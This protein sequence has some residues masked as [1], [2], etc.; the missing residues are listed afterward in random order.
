RLGVNV[1]WDRGYARALAVDP[2][3]PQTIYLGIDG[4]PEPARNH[5][6]G[7]VFKSTDGGKTWQ[8]L[9][10]QPTSR[11]MFFGLAVD[12]TDSRRLYWGA[13]NENGGVYRSDDGGAT[14]QYVFDKEKWVFNLAVG[15]SGEVYAG[16]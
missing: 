15:P 12:P 6:G 7:G 13:C 4:D 14:W 8:Q 1:M 11:R 3:D 9:P 2:N 5:A 10:D 16:H